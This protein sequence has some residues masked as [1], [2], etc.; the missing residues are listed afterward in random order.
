MCMGPNFGK[1]T[2]LSHNSL[3]PTCKGLIVFCMSLEMANF[4]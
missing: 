2:K 4:G 1:L 3:K